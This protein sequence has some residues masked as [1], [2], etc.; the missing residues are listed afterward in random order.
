[1]PAT[2]APPREKKPP[3]C[4]GWLRQDE[5]LDRVPF[6]PTTLWRKQQSGEFPPRRK[7][8]ANIVAWVEAEVEAF[9]TDRIN[10]GTPSEEEE[11]EVPS[12]PVSP[13][14]ATERKELRPRSRAAVDG[15]HP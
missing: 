10:G 3:R 2:P 4:P 8:S 5:V 15:G 14:P 1:M 11:E 6:S 13:V 9:L 7:I 12:E